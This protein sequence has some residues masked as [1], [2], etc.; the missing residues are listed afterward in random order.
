[1]FVFESG[2]EMG[3]P[4]ELFKNCA[5]YDGG[6]GETRPFGLCAYYNALLALGEH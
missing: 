1:M 2:A 5:L 6:E 4:H 3:Y